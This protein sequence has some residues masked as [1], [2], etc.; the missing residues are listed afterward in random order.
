MPSY[1]LLDLLL[2]FFSLFPPAF[3]IHA[4]DQSG[5]VTL[6]QNLVYAYACYTEQPDQS[7]VVLIYFSG[8][9]SLDC[10]SPED[11]TDSNIGINYISD[12][13]Y[14]QTGS[15]KRVLPEFRAD[16]GQRYWTVR[17]F[18]EGDKNCYNLTLR[19][20]DKYLIR[21]SFM[22]GNYD[23][24]NELPKFDLYIGPNF[25][26][27]VT[28]DDAGDA[29]PW[30]IIHVLQSRYLFI[31]LVN[32]G[33]GVP[34]ISAL[35]LR[36]LDNA[37][38][39]S[40]SQ[41]ESLMLFKRYDVG[42]T[43]TSSFRFGKDAY[44][45]IWWPYEEADW[46][47]IN[48]S[49]SINDSSHYQ[50][51]SLAIITAGTPANASQPMDIIMSSNTNTQFYVYMSFAEVENH[52]ANQSREF[53]IYHNGEEWYGP[54]NPKYLDV[55]TI[56]NPV[57]LKGI[58][59][60]I[61]RTSR[62]TLPPILNAF[63]IYKVNEFSQSQTN[64]N[65]VDAIVNIKS[66]HGI[67]RNWQ[68]DPCA[69]KLSWE[70]VNCSYVDFNPP[71]I[72]SLNLSSSNL[73][74]EIPPY[75]ANLS[76]LLYLDLSDNRLTGTVPEFL[77]NLQF[78]TMLN[79]SGNM[80]NGTVPVK[81][82]QRANQGLLDLNVEGNSILCESD[83]C[84]KKN[85]SKKK[86]IKNKT[87]VAAVVS[88]ASVLFIVIT[89]L[90]FL[91]KLKRRKQP[92]EK[93][94]VDTKKTHQ[95]QDSSK[96][97]RFTHAQVQR[98]TNN[99]ETEVGKGGFG[100]VFHGYLDDTQ[101]AVKMLSSS[102]VQGYK[103]FQAEVELLL[104]VHHRNLT[105]LIGYCDDGTNMGLIYEYMPKGNLA[106]H[107]KDSSRGVLNWEGRLGVA[108]EAAQGLEYLHNGCIPPII[109]RD[110]KSTNILLTEN[111]HA[112]LSDFGLSKAFPLDGDTHVFT[113][114]AG[115]PGYVDPEYSTSNR[116]TEK[117]DVYSFGVVLLE[118]IT[119][120]P[121]STKTYNQTTHISQW[122]SFM[123]SNGDIKTIVDPRLQ[124]D[125]DITSMKKAVELA[126]ACVSPT[127][128][129]RPTMSYVVSELNECLSTEIER[130]H[131]IQLASS[132]E[133]PLP[134]PR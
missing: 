114:V 92:A 9:I 119:S 83:S 101:V 18:P 26:D 106:E 57:P 19:K 112:K 134:T 69:Q 79:L 17:S 85:N 27:T 50:L 94:D 71:R 82:M 41:T 93:T 77:S 14:I 115:T 5:L 76:Q 13:P 8:F 109:H 84:K 32:T 29:F 40:Q 60:S 122:V 6:T 21:A 2:I 63:E 51:P 133:I 125:F 10:G 7:L 39:T 129:K 130:N 47:Q 104:R 102:S 11:Y 42:S 64:E 111:L 113:V 65:D 96:N 48:T 70:G 36:L 43:S 53:T 24:K 1:F 59:F 61:V 123:L 91:W 127:S 107:L 80:L 52:R 44:D 33:N 12:A 110:V 121:V 78:L 117:S 31:C 34:F 99:F 72:I 38:Y 88:V 49:F 132:E 68:G 46:L 16:V 3:L 73:R 87:I 103:E 55:T 67:K 45:R 37:T 15:S 128:T 75:I 97:R 25:W 30:D 54:F 124:G 118:I 20:G 131:S 81:L 86:N 100:T 66:T 108:L 56:Y 98:M 105:K 74:G 35:E 90:A 58:D 89:G 4:Q 95:L 116:L 28:L 22:Y 120:R 23:G 62:S 126:M